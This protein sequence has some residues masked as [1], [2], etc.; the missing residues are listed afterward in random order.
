MGL[1]SSA[2]WTQMAADTDVLIDDNEVDIDIRRGNTTIDTQQVR[3]VRTGSMT[4]RLES[5]GGDESRARVL[6][7][8]DTTLN[9]RPDDRVKDENGLLYRVIMVRPNRRASV[10]AECEMVA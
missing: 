3:I 4:Q 9:I 10:V 6:I 1:L 8:G 5:A 7:V 2:D